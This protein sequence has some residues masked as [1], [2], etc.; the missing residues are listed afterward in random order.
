M[1]KMGEGEGEGAFAIH[2]KLFGC[3]VAT[4]VGAVQVIAVV[5]TIN[6]YVIHRRISSLFRI[7][8]FTST[9]T[10][11]HHVLVTIPGY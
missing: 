9:A 3:Q 2:L 8:R 11:S 10:A 1:T 5:P 4:P 7:T 6:C